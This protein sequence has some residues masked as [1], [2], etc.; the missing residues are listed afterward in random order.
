MLGLLVTLAACGPAP[1][2]LSPQ[3]ILARAEAAAPGDP[4]LAELYRG[5]CR[6]CHARADSGAPLV[7]DHAAWDPRWAKGEATLLD[8][9]ISGFNG[10]PAGGQCFSCTTDDYRALIAFMAGKGG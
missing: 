6:E 7:H 10:M 2:H 3:Q 1:E 4:R 8:H 9:T 5:A